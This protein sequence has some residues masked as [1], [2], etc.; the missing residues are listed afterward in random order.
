MNFNTVSNLEE[1]F[2]DA[3]EMYYPH[4]QL[5]REVKLI[6]KRSFR[7]DFAHIPSKIAI[8]ING[9]NYKSQRSGHSTAVG[10]YRD[11]EK[12]NLAQLEGY[13]VFMLD[14]KMVR[15][16]PWYHRIAK[17]IQTNIEKDY[18]ATG[19]SEN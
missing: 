3:W 14:S 1:Y 8:E 11:Y 9:G 15:E 19:S 7:F 5:E 12:L 17:L 10:L 13:S 2:I 18:P 4:L 16:I 6:P